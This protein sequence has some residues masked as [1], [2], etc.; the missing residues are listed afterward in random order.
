MSAWGGKV[1]TARGLQVVRQL[2]SGGERWDL[3]ISDY[4]LG[5]NE[6]G[7]DVIAE[8]RARQGIG[9]PAI[10]ISGD[11]SSGLQQSASSAGHHLLYKPVKPAKLRSLLIFLLNEPARNSFDRQHQE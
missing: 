11:T 3:I 9:I 8:V 1:S 6:T 2:L 4:Q 7:F 10:L 5:M